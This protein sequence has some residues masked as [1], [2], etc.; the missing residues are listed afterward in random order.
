M[1]ALILNH[2]TRSVDANPWTLSIVTTNNAILLVPFLIGYA[3]SF[4]ETTSTST[5]KVIRLC[6]MLNI[7]SVVLGNLLI[8]GS[9]T[10]Y[11]KLTEPL[12]VL[13]V[14]ILVQG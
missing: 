2:I 4:H 8:G 9:V 13:I 11:L 1:Y 3:T 5:N 10:Y 12:V 7:W 14:E 6:N